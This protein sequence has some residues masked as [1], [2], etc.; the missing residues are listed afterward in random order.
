MN[1]ISKVNKVLNKNMFFLTNNYV[2]NNRVLAFEK[3]K[4]FGYFIQ[5]KI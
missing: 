5:L 4:L 1:V 2:E 3:T